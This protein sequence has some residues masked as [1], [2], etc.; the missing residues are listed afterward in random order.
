M[1]SHKNDLREELNRVTEERDN[2]HADCEA[3]RASLIDMQKKCEVLFRRL[4]SFIRQRNRSYDIDT[5]CLR[6]ME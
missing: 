6:D 2:L 3:L 4:N 5:A 1:N